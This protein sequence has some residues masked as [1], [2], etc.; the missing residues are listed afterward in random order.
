[1]KIVFTKTVP[2]V[3]SRY[4]CYR[5]KRKRRVFVGQVWKFTRN[6]WI[7][8]EW[9]LNLATTTG[10]PTFP[11]RHKAGLALTKS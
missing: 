8:G 3:R 4:N 2:F 6:S 5:L 11:T 10:I 1:M 9:A 7:N